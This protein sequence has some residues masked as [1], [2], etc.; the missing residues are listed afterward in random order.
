MTCTLGSKVGHLR[1]VPI[2]HHEVNV[3]QTESGGIQL[4]E[5]ICGT[6]SHVNIL[7]LLPSCSWLREWV[8]LRS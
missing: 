8:V 3:A 6:W 5:D 7:S 4:D 1:E 2:I